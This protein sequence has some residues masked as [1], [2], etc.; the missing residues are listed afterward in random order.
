MKFTHGN[1]FTSSGGGNAKPVGRVK[2]ELSPLGGHHQEKSCSST[3]LWGGT[4]DPI[5]GSRGIN[6]LIG[7]LEK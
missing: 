4:E 1:S 2:L 6:P 7:I 3:G 5:L